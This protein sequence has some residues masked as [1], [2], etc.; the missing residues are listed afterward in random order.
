MLMGPVSG[1]QT[2]DAWYNR[3][4]ALYNQGDLD[5]A[6]L[7]YDEAIQ[8]DPNFMDAWYKMGMVLDASVV[9]ALIYDGEYAKER[10]GREAL[11]CFEEVLRIEPNNITALEK[12]GGMLD[13]FHMY[14][15]AI[16][17][18]DKII[19]LAPKD[20]WTRYDAWRSKAEDCLKLEN[21]ELAVECYDQAIS[22]FPYDNK[23]TILYYDLFAKKAEALLKLGRNTEA[24]A[25]RTKAVEFGCKYC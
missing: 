12:K 9:P 18:Y 20:N 13:M 15:D 23:I 6:V 3:G 19:S 1:Q 14:A 10:T 7:A 11:R 22:A 25:A 24:E 8:L 4:N 21:Y 17:C 5:A 2:A 16:T